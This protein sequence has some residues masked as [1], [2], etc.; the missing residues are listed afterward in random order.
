MCRSI[1]GK[2]AISRG[3]AALA[4][5]HF[6]TAVLSLAETPASVASQG[7]F[8]QVASAEDIAMYIAM[9]ALVSFSRSEVK[10]TLLD[11]RS[12]RPFFDAAPAARRCLQA[13]LDS[14]YAQCIAETQAMQ[15]CIPPRNRHPPCMHASHPYPSQSTLQCDPWAKPVLAELVAAIRMQLVRQY[16]LPYSAISLNKMA[17]AFACSEEVLTAD[18]VELISSGSLPFRV[19]SAAGKLIAKQSDKRAASYARAQQAADDFVAASQGVLVRMSAELH[20]VSAQKGSGDAAGRGIASGVPGMP[21][22]LGG[23]G[24]GRSPLVEDE[25][26]D[27]DLGGGSLGPF[28]GLR[29]GIAGGEF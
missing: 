26:G 27:I 5:R 12:L 28:D 8:N 29:S 4:R 18:V 22:G 24:G 7:I 6:S 1:Q 13:F 17:A 3:V 20:G 25:E 16:C 19:D 10:A 14:E 9:T 21:R 11:R 2:V 15:V 23:L